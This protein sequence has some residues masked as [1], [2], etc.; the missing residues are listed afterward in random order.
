MSKFLYLED[1]KKYTSSDQACEGSSVNAE[2]QENGHSAIVIALSI[3][4][5]GFAA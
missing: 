5:L 4:F 1:T 2:N 3:T